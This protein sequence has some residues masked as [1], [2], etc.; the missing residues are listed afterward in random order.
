MEQ[1]VQNIPDNAGPML[2]TE[3]LNAA[4][5]STRSVPL[6]LK[7][8]KRRIFGNI[9]KYKVKLLFKNKKNSYDILLSIIVSIFL[10]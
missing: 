8:N 9:T 1:S 7:Q 3:I 5:C 10:V 2:G 6:T 4:F